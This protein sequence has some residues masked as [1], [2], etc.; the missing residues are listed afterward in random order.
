M[1]P[2]PLTLGALAVDLAQEAR[3][4]DG[5][6]AVAAASAEMVRRLR[7]HFMDSQS[8][9]A[10]ESLSQVEKGRGPADVSE[11]LAKTLDDHLQADEHGALAQ[12]LETILASAKEAGYAG[13][14][15]A[16][17]TITG[18]VGDDNKAIGGSPCATG[19]IGHRQVEKIFEDDSA[20]FLAPGTGDSGNPGGISD[21][22]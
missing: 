8:T 5:P 18:E 3:R 9:D 7:Q 12:Q 17:Q 4:R 6:D 1:E 19:S 13:P 10:E 15:P 2:V 14:S 22:F 16:S 20:G 21:D 11:S